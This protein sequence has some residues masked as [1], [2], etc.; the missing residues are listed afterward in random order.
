MAAVSAISPNFDLHIERRKRARIQVHWPVRFVR[1]EPAW[2]L[3]T[4]TRDLSSEG[5]KFAAKAPFVAGETW[6]CTLRVPA[7]DPK[8]SNRMLQV[9][10]NVRIAWV[11]PEADGTNVVGCHIEHYHFLNSLSIGTVATYRANEL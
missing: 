10:C 7:H 5:F 6:M 11:H 4:T 9:Q 2:S 3:D 8:D 1:R